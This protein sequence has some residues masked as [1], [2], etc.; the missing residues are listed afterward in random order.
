MTSRRT[1]ARVVGDGVTTR[2]CVPDGSSV[3]TVVPVPVP[4]SVDVAV[5]ATVTVTV[6]TVVSMAFRRTTNTGVLL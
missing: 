5:A 2:I 3:A 4:V 1:E 6:F